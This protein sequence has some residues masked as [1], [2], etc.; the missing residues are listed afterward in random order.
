MSTDWELLQPFGGRKASGTW[1][2]G[3]SMTACQIDACLEQ[4]V[5]I[6]VTAAVIKQIR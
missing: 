4:A 6:R 2:G 5:R 3:F 1:I